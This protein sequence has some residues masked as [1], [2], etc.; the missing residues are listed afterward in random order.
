[1]SSKED[2]PIERVHTSFQQL[3][4]GAD[5]LNTRSDQVGKIVSRIDS[6]FQKLNV[7]VSGWVRFKES[8]S[9]DGLQF[10]Y[11]EVGY[12]KVS[13]KWGL[14]IRSVAGDERMDV[15]SSYEEWLFNDAPRA[16][17]I[18]AVDKIP[19]LFEKLGNEVTA[20]TAAVD[21][22]LTLLEEFANAVEDVVTKRK[23]TISEMMGSLGSR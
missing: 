12:D 8:S 15:Y 20:L 18:D 9:E 17:R 4:T 13:G 19:E 7:G 16:L 3:S 2:S 14:A 11:N 6:S 22:K 1:M 5:T 21:K 10:W 23:R